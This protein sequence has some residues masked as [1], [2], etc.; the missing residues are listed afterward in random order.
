M[1]EDHCDTAGLSKN[2]AKWVF[3][4]G[5]DCITTFPYN[6]RLVIIFTIFRFAKELY[7]FIEGTRVGRHKDHN[8]LA[9]I[10]TY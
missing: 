8:T 3:L 1:K 7:K 10:E 9:P 4:R 5:N 2:R 6:K